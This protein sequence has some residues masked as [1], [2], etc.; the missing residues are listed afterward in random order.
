[1]TIHPY[2]RVFSLLLAWEDDG[3]ANAYKGGVNEFKEQMKELAEIFEYCYSFEVEIWL[4]PSE[5]PSRALD[6]KLSELFKKGDGSKDSHDVN[7]TLFIIYYGGHAIPHP[8]DAADLYLV[9]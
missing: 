6:T 3:G 8:D 9:P 4:I 5:S 7:S 1:M 2:K